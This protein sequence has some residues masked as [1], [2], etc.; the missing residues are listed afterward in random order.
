MVSAGTRKAMSGSLPVAGRPRF[1]FGITFI[2]FIA[3]LR[4]YLN[5]EPMGSF[6]IGYS[7][8]AS[9]ARKISNAIATQS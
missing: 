2:D 6:A 4:L 9:L 1:F 3:I 8:S 5:G 7:L